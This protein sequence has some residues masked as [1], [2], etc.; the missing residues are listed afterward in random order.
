MDSL[1]VKAAHLNA[2][3]DCEL[4]MAQPEGYCE[5]GQ[6]NLVCKLHKSLYGLKQSGRNW[7]SMLNE[8]LI[9]FGCKKSNGD[10]CVYIIGGDKNK[11][12]GM[13]LIWVDDIIMATEHKKLLKRI[14]DHLKG[15][16]RMKDMG[17]V[18]NFLGIR[19]LQSK[20]KIEMD[21]TQYLLSILQKY[22]MSDCKPRATPCELKPT[23]SS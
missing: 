22:G 14:K 21:Q 4:Y 3:I 2:P 23:N 5:G 15:K 18:S 1:D 16:F 8:S 19:F 12:E 7:N 10:S 20:S 17:R 13:I 9:R 6:E 11:L